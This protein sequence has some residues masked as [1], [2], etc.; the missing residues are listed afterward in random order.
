M[1]V[2]NTVVPDNRQL[3]FQIMQKENP[4]DILII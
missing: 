3:V 1:Y 2:N 4:S